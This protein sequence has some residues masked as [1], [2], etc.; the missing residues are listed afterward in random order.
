MKLYSKW[1]CF[2]GMCIIDNK[3]QLGFGTSPY[4]ELPDKVI[5]ELLN[6]VE[7]GE[8]I[9][10]IMGDHNPKQKGGAIAFFTIGIVKR[11]DFYVAGLTVALVPFMNEK[12]YFR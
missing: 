8:V 12:L 2:G 9:D 4:F 1:F 11:K 3:G 5:K 10:K 7:L 6:G